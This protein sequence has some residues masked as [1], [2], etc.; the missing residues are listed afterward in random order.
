LDRFEVE[1]VVGLGQRDPELRLELRQLI[2]RQLSQG[3]ADG[4]TGAWDAS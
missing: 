4:R 1:G 2:W 3:G